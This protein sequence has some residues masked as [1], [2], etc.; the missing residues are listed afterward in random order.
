M[1]F[2]LPKIYPITDTRISG[3][4]HVEQVRRL[5]A[6]G[7]SLIQLRDKHAPAGE[8]YNAALEAID[9][10]RERGVKVIINDRVDI[11]IATRADGVH[12]GQDDLSPKDVRRLIGENAVVG[13]STHSAA[14]AI[15]AISV[16]V[17]YVA[18][19]PIFSTTTQD[20]PDPIV[21]L[22]G[23]RE[24]RTAIGA[25]PL[26]A[27]GG[28]GRDNARSVLDAGAHTV[29]VISDILSDGAGIESSMCKFN[30]L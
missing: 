5:I 7:A 4:S 13:V 28:I 8:F 19:G 30:D 23:L 22:E 18:I 26:V 1:K 24:V 11:A 16:P 6:G 25:F 27:I 14:Q 12:V 9:Y 21:G 17:D 29:A 10:A 2:T 15:A 3:L 20:N